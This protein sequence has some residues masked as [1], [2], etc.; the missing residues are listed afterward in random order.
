MAGVATT[1]MSRLGDG[2]IPLR[3]LCTYTTCAR[4]AGD[5][6]GDTHVRSTDKVVHTV[7]RSSRH[8]C[9]VM[10]GIRY[11]GGSA[12]GGGNREACVRWSRSLDLGLRETWDVRG[13]TG[14]ARWQRGAPAR[15]CASV[16]VALRVE[17]KQQKQQLQ[18]MRMR[19]QGKRSSQTSHPGPQI[20][21]RTAMRQSVG[22]ACLPACLSPPLSDHLTNANDDGPCPSQCHACTR[23][24]LPGRTLAPAACATSHTCNSA[25]KLAQIR[26]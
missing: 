14:L 9:D 3:L 18:C 16:C 6:D 5:G 2:C 26:S 20:I 25:G 8:A 13:A 7:V 15:S 24:V 19:M 11:A 22:S 23:L 4:T 21:R 1:C 12:R 17:E 10:C